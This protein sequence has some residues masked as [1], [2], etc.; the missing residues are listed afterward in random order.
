MPPAIWRDGLAMQPDQSEK[1]T[2]LAVDDE[3]AI[4]SLLRS[5]LPSGGF[6]ALVAASGLEAIELF[7]Q[8]HDE[9]GVVLLD[10]C[11]PGLNGVETAR[12]LREIDRDLPLCFMTGY[13]SDEIK[14]DLSEF[15]APL[16][17]KPFSLAALFGI[18]L[19]QIRS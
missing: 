1:R 17:Y 15:R 19:G 8:R 6:K 7:T 3:P 9:I 14:L 13:L 4:R 11:M 10:I 16:L 2:V 18:L 12:L 5:S